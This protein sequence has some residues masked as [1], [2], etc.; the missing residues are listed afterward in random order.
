MKRYTGNRSLPGAF[1][2]GM[3]YAV[4]VFAVGFV[5]GSVRVLVA[6]PRLGGTIA[7]LLEAPAMLAVSWWVS[8]KCIAVFR[9]DE[10]VLARLLMGTT[11]FTVLM[12][13]EVAVAAL[14]FGESFT[15]YLRRL[16]SVPGAIGLSAQL[17]FASFPLAQ[18]KA[19]V[20]TATSSGK[21]APEG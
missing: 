5:L 7:V 4:V 10:E 17:A 15:M 6:A 16:T 1:R 13:A 12:L 2:A 21:R 20:L 19:G 18:I 8:R 14:T 11:A 9:V 3:V